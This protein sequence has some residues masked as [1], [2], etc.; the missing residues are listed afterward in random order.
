MSDIAKLWRERAARK[1]AERDAQIVP[2][3]VTFAGFTG[4]AHRLPLAAWARAGRL[5]EYLAAAMFAAVRGRSVERRKSEMSPEELGQ[6]NRFQCVAFCS[7]MD[8]PRFA[9]KPESECA[10]DEL[11]YQEFI[12]MCPEAVQEGIQ[13]QLDGC[14]DIPVLLEGGD[15]MTLGE[16][17]SFRDGGAGPSP[18]ESLFNRGGVWWDTRP[19]PRAL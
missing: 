5:P 4:R 11:S 3:P 8:E 16:L 19:T 2:V 12:L 14:P 7:M 15:T 6:W 18:S 17:T 10:E 9:D 13:W 1:A